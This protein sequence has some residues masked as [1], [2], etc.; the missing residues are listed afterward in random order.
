MVRLREIWS[1]ELTLMLRYK[2]LSFTLAA[3]I[4]VACGAETKR[5]NFGE[6]KD[7][8]AEPGQP[9]FTPGQEP[10]AGLEC[11]RVNCGGE[12]TTTLTGKVYDPAGANPIYNV[13]VYIPGGADPDGDLPPFSES[14]NDGI[15]CQACNTVALSPLV[16]ALTNSKGEFVLENVPIEKDVPVIVHH[17]NQMRIQG[18]FPNKSMQS[19]QAPNGGSPPQAQ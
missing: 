3:G 17:V 9:G 13:Q 18:Q 11:K 5:S 8:A 7:E 4:L 19:V 1:K 14:I 16:S 10:C 15:T 2:V 12:P 6:K